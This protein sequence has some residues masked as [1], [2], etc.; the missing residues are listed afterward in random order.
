M[1]TK[2]ADTP[3]HYGNRKPLHQTTQ[4]AYEAGE[5][6]KACLRLKAMTDVVWARM[7]LEHELAAVISYEYLQGNIPEV[8][9][10]NQLK[11]NELLPNMITFYPI[12]GVLPEEAR[13]SHCQLQSCKRYLKYCLLSVLTPRKRIF[14]YIR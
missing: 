8:I 9:G 5:E 10:Y 14:C 1:P 7:Q 2:E 13:K 11:I 4:Q 12:D 6:R 3:V